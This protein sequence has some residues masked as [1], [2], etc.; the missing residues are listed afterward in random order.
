MILACLII[1]NRGKPRLNKFYERYPIDTQKKLIREV[2]Q[3]ISKRPP[4][5]CNFLENAYG[6]WGKGNGVKIVY[7][8]YAT[9]CFIMV[10]DSA[11]SELGIMDLIQSFVECL[12]HQFENVCELDLIFHSDKVHFI[13]DE[14]ILGGLVIEAR[15]QNILPSLE[16]QDKM[17]RA[18]R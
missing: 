5:A 2:Y 6:F 10:V 14:M 12:D 18:S 16:A 4:S 9:L 13:L 17:D 15:Y 1:N 7:R 11:E 8:T 3:A